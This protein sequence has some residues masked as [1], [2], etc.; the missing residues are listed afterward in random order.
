MADKILQARLALKLD[1]TLNWEA[2]NPILKSG[3]V[4]LEKVTG[5]SV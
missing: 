2:S 5:G 3:E 4:G 1:T